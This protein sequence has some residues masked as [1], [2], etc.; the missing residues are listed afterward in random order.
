MNEWL[1][2]SYNFRSLTHVSI[3][4]CISVL[5]SIAAIVVLLWLLTAYQ[6]CLTVIKLSVTWLRGL[7]VT[8]NWLL[9]VTSHSSRLLAIRILNW[10]AHG[11]LLLLLLHHLLLH[12]LLL[13]HGIVL[14][15][16]SLLLIRVHSC[17]SH[18]THAA[19]HHRI[20]GN[21]A[22]RKFR[23]SNHSLSLVLLIHWTWF[24]VSWHFLLA[25][26]FAAAFASDCSMSI[27]IFAT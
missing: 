4:R 12:H 25:G 19:H 15:H 11:I 21:I 8:A 23:N 26:I 3:I 27:S 16:H 14:L 22:S 10:L 9:I 13:H 24:G 2:G 1:S 7:L 17:T 18:H 5:A 20:H 6:R